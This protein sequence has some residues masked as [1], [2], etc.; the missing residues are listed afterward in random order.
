MTIEIF[1]RDGT[2]DVYFKV[3]GDS[4]KSL[5]LLYA[6]DTSDFNI[7]AGL[8]VVICRAFFNA[9][10]IAIIHIIAIKTPFQIFF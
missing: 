7:P 5:V 1:A 8:V 4:S 10:L 9:Q 2:P 6:P 3:N